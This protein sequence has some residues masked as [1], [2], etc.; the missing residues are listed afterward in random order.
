MLSHFLA[1]SLCSVS[2]L[3]SVWPREEMLLGVDLVSPSGLIRWG[4]LGHGTTCKL[5]LL[6]A[7]IFRMPTTYTYWNNSLHYDKYNENYLFYDLISAY[8][9]WLG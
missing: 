5:K 8:N 6:K 3:A 4:S 9:E 7:T 2:W 1:L